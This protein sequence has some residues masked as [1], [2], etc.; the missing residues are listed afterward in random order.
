MK[1]LTAWLILCSSAV[2]AGV[3]CPADVDAAYLKSLVQSLESDEWLTRCHSR[4]L[5]AQRVDMPCIKALKAGMTPKN[6]AETRRV[7]SLLL[8]SWYSNA[9]SHDPEYPLPDIRFLPKRYKDSVDV[10]YAKAKQKVVMSLDTGD[11]PDDWEIDS[12]YHAGEDA[13]Y[14]FLSGK[15]DDGWSIDE[16]RKLADEMADNFHKDGGYYYDGHG[17]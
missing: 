17:E 16:V 7:C 13:T 12:K 3:P 15:L 14:M 8:D 9:C 1:Y 10:W 11:K 4:L 6:G 2:A 5:L